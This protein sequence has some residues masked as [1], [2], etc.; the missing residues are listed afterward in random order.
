MTNENNENIT[1]QDT[2]KEAQEALLNMAREWHKN[3]A[4]INHAIKAYKD[5]I[6]TF[7]SESPEVDEAKQALLKIAKEWEKKG[8]KYAAIRLYKELMAYK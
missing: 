7:D 5:I 6:A 2:S 4:A 8:K 3:P 1:E